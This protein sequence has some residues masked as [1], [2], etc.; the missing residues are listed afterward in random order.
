MLQLER[1]PSGLVWFGQLYKDR[2]FHAVI[3]LHY[4]LRIATCAP[5]LT[6][7]PQFDETVS[8]VTAA[9]WEFTYT[10]LS[11]SNPPRSR[12]ALLHMVTILTMM[13]TKKCEPFEQSSA[14]MWAFKR[15][16]EG[17][18]GSCCIQAAGSWQGLAIHKGTTGSR[19]IP[20]IELHA[21]G[22]AGDG[23]GT[24]PSVPR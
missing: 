19:Y 5:C 24:H 20:S 23:A 13:N 15:L 9:S 11:C 3:E 4:E 10:F 14:I 17:T 2:H 21:G 7:C 12:P 8:P 18:L 16:C 1:K 22:G 6:C